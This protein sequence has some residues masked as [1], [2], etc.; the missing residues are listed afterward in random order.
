MKIIDGLQLCFWDGQDGTM[1]RILVECGEGKAGDEG[2]TPQEKIDYGWNVE[3]EACRER[4]IEFQRLYYRGMCHD[5][6]GR[7]W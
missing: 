1:R 7:Y 6:T 2:R 5:R 3:A 4:G